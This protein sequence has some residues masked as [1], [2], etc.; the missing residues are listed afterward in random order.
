MEHERAT[1]RLDLDHDGLVSAATSGAF[2]LVGVGLYAVD[3]DG[4]IRAMNTKAAALLGWTPEQCCG[5]DAHETLHLA[6]YS[7]QGC[8]VLAV[9]R[10]GVSQEMESD[11]FRCSDGSLLPVRWSAT[12]IFAPPAPRPGDLVGA[13]VAFTD[14]T[15]SQQAT[16][17]EAAAVAQVSS[18]LG[19]ARQTVSDLGWA[20]EVTQALAS[21][22][23]E[24]EA[25]RRL[26][27]MAVPRLCDVIVVH[28]VDES[29]GRQRIAA[30]FAPDL[31]SEFH[32][33]I[34]AADRQLDP[35]KTRP[36]ADTAGV[37]TLL[38]APELADSTLIDD[39][40][41]ALVRVAGSSAVLI[42]PMAA[43]GHVVAVAEMIYRAGG[44][45]FD[46]SDR[47]AAVELARR[48]GL[49][50]DNLR[51]LQTQRSAALL[52]QEALLPALPRRPGLR[53]AG[54]YRPSGEAHL[55]GGDWY[56]AFACPSDPGATMLVVGD[57]AGHDLE[58]ATHMAAIRNLLRGIAVAVPSDPARLLST[59]DEH[60]D[61]LGI[62]V[63]ATVIAAS[64]SLQASPDA[65][66]TGDWTLRWS[67][68][69]H[70]PPVLIHPGG[71]VERL[72]QPPEPLL[73]A[74]TKRAR[75]CHSRQIPHGTMIVFY[76]DGLVERPGEDLDLALDRLATAIRLAPATQSGHPEA[77][78]DHILD[79][80]APSNYDDTAVLVARLG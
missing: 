52:L 11:V 5:L 19:A 18:D 1:Q 57:V 2:D 40:T 21:A 65:E 42:V 80:M 23:D 78:L 59:V 55:I 24:H 31:G 10:T 60:L 32:Q 72:D 45:N 70:V 51:V 44:A 61:D 17:A 34:E 37:V 30:V 8:P 76:T 62:P 43:R 15:V 50:F 25:L 29:G 9:A 69:G 13:L 48:A 56:D 49:A 14:T 36:G 16:V 27:R 26:A 33:A 20:A 39:R 7:D 54:R 3:A 46:D 63:T 66:H 12:P 53:L 77:L 67:N 74:G 35:L 28:R 38:E 22:P 6:G 41:R 47:L 58:A 64:V 79:R 4:L 75:T 71:D 73:G 68:A